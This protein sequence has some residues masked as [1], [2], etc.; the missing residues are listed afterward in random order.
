MGKI[1]ISG[2][3]LKLLRYWLSR[4][5]TDIQIIFKI[6]LFIFKKMEK[7]KKLINLDSLPRKCAYHA[8]IWMF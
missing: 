1:L 3:F 8:L 7:T 6:N 2:F 4:R 5:S